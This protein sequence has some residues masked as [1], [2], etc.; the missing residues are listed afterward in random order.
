MKIY[1][2]RRDLL[3]TDWEGAKREID[4]KAELSREIDAFYRANGYEDNVMAIYSPMEFE[5]AFNREG[6]GVLNGHIYWIKV[7]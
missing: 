2:G 5:A 1:V 7:F 4:Y 6:S 3:P